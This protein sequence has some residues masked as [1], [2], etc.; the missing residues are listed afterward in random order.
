MVASTEA[1]ARS[2]RCCSA[3]G[4]ARTSYVV[5]HGTECTSSVLPKAQEIEVQCYILHQVRQCCCDLLLSLGA[6]VGVLKG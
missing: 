6:V 2:A 5:A 1:L 4:V 3:Q